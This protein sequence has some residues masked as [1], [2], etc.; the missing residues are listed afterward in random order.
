[1]SV[2]ARGFDGVVE[3]LTGVEGW[4]TD[5]QARDLW[6]A[7]L[8]VRAPG[9]IVEI[10]SFRGRSTIVLACA[11][12]DGVEV[13]AIDPH[14]GGD[15]GPQEIAP[16]ARRGEEDLAA[17][18]DNLR[19]AGVQERVRH[20]RA[21]SGQALAAIPG[22]ADLL[23][24]DGAHRYRPA[25]ADIEQWGARVPPGGTMIL[26]DAFN[27]IGVTLAQLRLLALA[28]RWRYIGRTGSLASYR[29]ESVPMRAGGVV[30]NAARQLASLPYFGR[31]LLVKVLIVARLRPAARLLGHREGDWPY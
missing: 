23:F 11:A 4:L 9:R 20:V 22:A 25:R 12:T 24:V 8:R 19:R 31:N 28:T 29:R 1:V 17:F 30:A 3:L 6:D 26:H 16:D 10:G 21:A 2:A 15:R 27:A 18:Q 14:G 5:A 7:A 13:V